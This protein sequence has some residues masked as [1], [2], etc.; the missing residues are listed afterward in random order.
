MGKD[1]GVM[2]KEAKVIQSRFKLRTFCAPIC[3]PDVGQMRMIKQFRDVHDSTKYP[4]MQVDSTKP[5]VRFNTKGPRYGKV[6][7]RL[8]RLNCEG[9]VDIE[10]IY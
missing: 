6:I 4:R 9:E 1:F 3:G 7:I 2:M 8:R 10:K 5:D